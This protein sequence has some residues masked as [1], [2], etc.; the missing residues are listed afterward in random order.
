[1][2]FG[3]GIAHRGISPVNIY[4]CFAGAESKEDTNYTCLLAG[5]I[6][7]GKKPE[8]RWYPGGAREFYSKIV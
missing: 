2:R 7:S 4:K 6:G 5:S 3:M 8:H 1:M